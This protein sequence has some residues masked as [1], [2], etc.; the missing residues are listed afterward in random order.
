MVGESWSQFE[1]LPELQGKSGQGSYPT[2]ERREVGFATKVELAWSD[3]KARSM[4]KQERR[5]LAEFHA[6]AGEVKLLYN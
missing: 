1:S 3:E 6:C 2:L 4:E 5:A